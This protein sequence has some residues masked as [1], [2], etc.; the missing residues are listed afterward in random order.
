LA[1]VI[2]LNAYPPYYI[3]DW[4]A[5]TY[6]GDDNRAGVARSM[7]AHPAGKG[8]VQDNQAAVEQL[9]AKV[10][11]PPPLEFEDHVQDVMF[12]LAQLLVSKQ[13][14]Y[15]PHAINRAPGGALNG[16]LVR[17]HDKVERLKNL[18]DT[19]RNPDHESVRD[20]WRDAANYAVI[21]LMVIDGTWPE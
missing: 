14:D 13:A 8:R 19:D 17:L 16:I 20:T 4:P 5:G 12:D 3:S 9:L 7:A 2:N 10:T 6:S 21:A 15:G 18:A 11:A 1:D